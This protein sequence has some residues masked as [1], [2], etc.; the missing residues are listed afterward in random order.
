M[1]MSVCSQDT[2]KCI[3]PKQKH[4]IAKFTALGPQPNPG[5]GLYHQ[6]P[7]EGMGTLKLLL[8][9]PYKQKSVWTALE[10]FK[11]FPS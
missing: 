1:A 7:S 9:C 11:R 8:T 5:E 3:L 4:K 6:I 10:T 2:H